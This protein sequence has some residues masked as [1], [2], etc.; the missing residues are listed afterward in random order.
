[1]KLHQIQALVA[2]A[3]TG[4]IRAAAR[5]LGISQAAVTRAL[6]ELEA[7]QKLPLL[8]RAPS[9]LTFTQFG[10]ALLTH[11]RLVLNQLDLAENE[12]A[13]MRGRAEGKLCVGITPWVMHSF[14]PETIMDFRRQMPSVRLELYESLMAITQP[15]LRDGTMDFVVGYLQSSV[16]EFVSDPLLTYETA[17]LV[18]RDHSRRD[19]RSIHDL[20]DQNWALNYAP[21]GH[22]ALMD[23]L[24][25]RFGANIE[26]HQIVRAHS[27]SMMQTLVE[28]GMCTWS[29]A[30]LSRMPPF[31][32][33][34][35][36]VPLQEQFE[37]RLLSIITRRNNTRSSAAACFIDCLRKVIRRRSRSGNKEER[38]IFD[39]LTLIA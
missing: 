36:T 35:V 6:R 34:V 1:M 2:S 32:D 13:E 8:V 19:S 24:F 5:S 16:T 30:V 11:A 26:E 33:R 27:S 38:Q 3:E 37:P 18:R 31:V 10:S 17:V 23:H 20:L 15:L 28:A 7:S 22:D 29:P 9:G 4:S 14:L 12:L 25:W 21:D 39:T